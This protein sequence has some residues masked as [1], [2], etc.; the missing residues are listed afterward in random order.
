MAAIPL[1]LF[2]QQFSPWKSKV[3]LTLQGAERAI[4]QSKIALSAP[5]KEIS[6]CR[7]LYFP[8]RESLIFY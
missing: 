8:K 4:L 3:K 2:Y 6:Q 1:K 7:R 5:C